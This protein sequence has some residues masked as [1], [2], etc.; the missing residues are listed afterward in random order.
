MLAAQLALFNE[1]AVRAERRA[2]E[3]EG[4]LEVART[5]PVTGLAVRRVAEQHL[6]DTAGSDVTVALID[7]DDLHAINDAIGHDGGDVF[8]AAVAERLVHAAE[9]GDLVARLGGDEFVLITGRDP[10]ELARGL[11][12]AI[13]QPVTIGSATLPM[14]VSIGICRVAG[15][16]PRIAF[17]CSDLAMFTAKWQGSVIEHYDPVR[18]GVPLSHGVRPSV[19]HRDRGSGRRPDSSA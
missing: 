8:L 5:D 17:G 6:R 9:P 15:G 3:L 13:T 19:R 10:H 18:D 4:E 2:E 16:D 11:S 14:H 1:R 12:A 7:V